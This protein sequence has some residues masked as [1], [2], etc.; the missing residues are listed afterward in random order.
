MSASGHHLILREEI[1]RLSEEKQD[2]EAA[3]REWELTNVAFT[4]TGKCICTHDVKWD[5]WIRNILN[6]TETH[7]G[8][9]CINHFLNKTLTDEANEQQKNL[10][11]KLMGKGE[12][13][14]CDECG[15]PTSKKDYS[16]TPLHKK[17]DSKRIWDRIND[18]KRKEW[19][20]NKPIFDNEVQKLLQ[21]RSKMDERDQSFLDSIL[22][23]SDR[24]MSNKQVKVIHKYMKKYCPEFVPK[25][26][27]KT[28]KKK[29][30]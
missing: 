15:G 19:E 20:Q 2:W 9:E 22:K 16:G 21:V 17:C 14:K 7:V 30:N 27:K 1:F 18:D 5:F 25:P 11:R 23:Q 29:S 4:Q 24:G 6:K 26:E 3:S 13:Y 28:R 12:L 8:S 10:K